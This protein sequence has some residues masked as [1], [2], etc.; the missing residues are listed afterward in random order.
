LHYSYL[1]ASTGLSLE[2]FHA[3]KKPDITPTIAEIKIAIAA[4][5]QGKV[6]GKN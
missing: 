6:V 3:G 5:V 4:T 1:S 2:A